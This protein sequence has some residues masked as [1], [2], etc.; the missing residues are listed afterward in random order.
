MTTTFAALFATLAFTVATASTPLTQKDKK[1][2]TTNLSGRWSMSV[3]GGP[4]GATTMGLELKQDGKKISGT[5]ASPHGDMPIEGEFVDG[6]LNFATKEDGP[7]H[8][9][10]TFKATLKDNGTLAGYISSQMGDMT[11]TGQRV[12]DS[13]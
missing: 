9:A 1:S 12:K 10:I 6:T 8:P 7:D 5:F 4:H 13:Q 2:D 11:W 3:E